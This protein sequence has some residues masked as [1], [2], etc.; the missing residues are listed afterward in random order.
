MCCL[1]LLK[2]LGAQEHWCVLW[3]A[4]SFVV[5][6]KIMNGSEWVCARGQVCVSADII[7]VGGRQYHLSITPSW[8]ARTTC[9]IYLFSLFIWISFLST[10]VW[11][12]IPNKPNI[13]FV[14]GLQWCLS[15]STF[16]PVSSGPSSSVNAPRLSTTLAT[17][18]C[19][20]TPLG[21]SSCPSSYIS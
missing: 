1:Q 3:L 14:V 4:Y 2:V 10:I 5:W 8:H 9:V 16:N 6:T 11:L 20:D 21:Y 13:Y 7:W 19:V 12:N 17:L 18:F 15:F